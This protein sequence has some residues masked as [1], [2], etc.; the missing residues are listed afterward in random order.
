MKSEI[1]EKGPRDF[2][3]HVFGTN[4]PHFIAGAVERGVEQTGTKPKVEIVREAPLEAWYSIR[5]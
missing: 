5:W 4:T 2:E 1:V 3:L